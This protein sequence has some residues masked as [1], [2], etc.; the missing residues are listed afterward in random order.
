[1]VLTIPQSSSMKVGYL[2]KLFSRATCFCFFSIGLD[3]SAFD[4]KSVSFEEHI[5]LQHNMWHYLFF[6]VLLKVKDPTE[7]TGPESYV[8]QMI[9]VLYNPG[10]NPLV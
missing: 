6:I 10:Y 7:F 1:M 3:R 5:K 8:A 9:K 2:T 4:N